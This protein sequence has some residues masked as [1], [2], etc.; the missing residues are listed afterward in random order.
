M[1]TRAKV[2]ALILVVLCCSAVVLTG[3]K[4]GDG[5]G[6]DVDWLYAEKSKELGLDWDA[7][8]KSV[9]NFDMAGNGF[10]IDEENL[11]DDVKEFYSVSFT[12]YDPAVKKSFKK[13][14]NQILI[15]YGVGTKN[16]YADEELEY[17]DEPVIE[18][19]ILSN[20]SGKSYTAVFNEKRERLNE[21]GQWYLSSDKEETVAGYIDLCLNAIGKK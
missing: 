3:C 21:D 15:S 9:K 18:I 7:I 19:H 11:E 5:K 13:V 14:E 8:I 2:F 4:M 12:N 10:Y 6:N 17:F 20:S 1:K 16:E